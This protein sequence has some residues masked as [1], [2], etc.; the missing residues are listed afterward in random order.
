LLAL[1]L[2]E[3]LSIIYRSILYV[4]IGTVDFSTRMTLS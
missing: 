3:T 1:A 2:T 4:P